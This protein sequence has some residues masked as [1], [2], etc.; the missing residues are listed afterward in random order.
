MWEGAY[1]RLGN[2]RDAIVTIIGLQS[3]T[4]MLKRRRFGIV[5]NHCCKFSIFRVILVGLR[6]LLIW[7]YVI[8]FLYVETFTGRP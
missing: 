5:V 7:Q 3:F 1:V 4:I 2:L 6:K 8:G